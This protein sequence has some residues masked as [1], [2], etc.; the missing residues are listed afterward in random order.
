[1]PARVPAVRQRDLLQGSRDQEISSRKAAPNPGARAEIV[2]HSQGGEPPS[3]RLDSTKALRVSNTQ[4][5]GVHMQ[6]T[7]ERTPGELAAEFAR[8]NE[9][10]MYSEQACVE[11]AET[12]HRIRALKVQRNAVVLAH[13]YQRPEI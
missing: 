8:L 11:L 6:P 5:R 2:A 9:P 1:M 10:Q 12:I 13:N 4:T 7:T 3:G